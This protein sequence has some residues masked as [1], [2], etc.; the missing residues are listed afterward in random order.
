ML[1]ESSYENQF[2]EVFEESLEI[3]PGYVPE[4]RDEA[5][6]EVIHHAIPVAIGQHILKDKEDYRD[7]FGIDEV[8]RV[9]TEGYEFQNGVKAEDFAITSP[10]KGG[11][12][13]IGQVVSCNGKNYR[14]QK[15]FDILQAENFERRLRS[16]NSLESAIKN[17]YT[18]RTDFEPEEVITREQEIR[19]SLEKEGKYDLD[20]KIIR[21]ERPEEINWNQVNSILYEN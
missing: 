3:K 21:L 20:V 17:L 10:N 6:T 4:R 11:E 5:Y 1:V 14:G 9:L 19:Q 12:L 7:I 13:V 8:S 2:S 18:V 15:S 16:S